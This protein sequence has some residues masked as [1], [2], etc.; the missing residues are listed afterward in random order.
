MTR[1]RLSLEF[2]A[3]ISGNRDLDTLLID[4]MAESGV[5]RK[6]NVRSKGQGLFFHA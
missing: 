5:N 3:V 4:L 2:L 6:R 1:A